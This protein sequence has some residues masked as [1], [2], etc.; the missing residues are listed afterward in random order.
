MRKRSLITTLVATLLIIT[1]SAFPVLANAP[2]GK[3]IA[4]PVDTTKKITDIKQAINLIENNFLGE[5]KNGTSFIKDGADKYIDRITLNQIT[6]GMNS[7]NQ[8]IATGALYRDSITNQLKKSDT[9]D[10]IVQ[11]M[12][13]SSDITGSYIWHWYGFDFVMEAYSSNLFGIELGKQAAVIA[14][15]ASPFWAVPQIVVIATVGV[16]A[17]LVMA[18]NALTG[19]GNG[20][21]SIAFF[22]GDP[23]WAQITHVDVR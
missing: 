12:A 6:S 13:V 5:N 17:I 1:V 14:G 16:S 8:R 23:S 2:A 22:L 10:A 11:P 20:R 3:P 19:G 21:G 7:I 4:T 18:A 15:S 9:I